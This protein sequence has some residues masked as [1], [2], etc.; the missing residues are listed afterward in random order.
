MENILDLS[1]DELPYGVLALIF[2]LCG[3]DIHNSAELPRNA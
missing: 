1:I 3:R 2:V